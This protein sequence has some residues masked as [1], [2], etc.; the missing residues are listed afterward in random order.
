[1]NFEW[2]EKKREKTLQERGIDFVDAAMIWLD[3]RKQERVDNRQKYGETRFQA[4]GQS[5]L[6]ILFVVYTERVKENETEVIRII[7]VRKANKNEKI[8]YEKM[9]FHTRVV[10]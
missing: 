10:I 8:D 7:S 9:L 1:M 6:G 3:P 4:I 2:D 5:K